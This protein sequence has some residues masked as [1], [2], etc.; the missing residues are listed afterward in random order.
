MTDIDIDVTAY[1]GLTIIAPCCHEEIIFNVSMLDS[2][3]IRCCA[4][5]APVVSSS[6]AD[7]VYDTLLRRVGESPPSL[8]VGDIDQIKA[9]LRAVELGRTGVLLPFCRRC[10]HCQSCVP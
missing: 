1:D 8:N 4:C 2:A 9:W 7:V 3:A 6:L 10:V 5:H